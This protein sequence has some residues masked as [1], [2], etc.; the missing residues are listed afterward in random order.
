MPSKT[1]ERKIVL[2]GAKTVFLSTGNTILSKKE[3]DSWSGRQKTTSVNHVRGRDGHYHEGGPFYT[4]A[5]TYSVPHRDVKVFDKN[6]TTVYQGPLFLSPPLPGIT[7]SAHR[8]ED[9]SDLDKFGAEAISRV[10]P[11]NASSHLAQQVGELHQDGIVRSLPGVATWRNRTKVL[12]AAGSEYLSAVFG[13][14]PLVDEI[15][16]VSNNIRHSDTILKNYDSG[17]GRNSHREYEFPE[18]QSSGPSGSQTGK[19]ANTVLGL[20]SSFNDGP[21]GTL[22]TSSVTTVKRWFSGSFTYPPAPK[23][24]ALDKVRYAAH[25]ADYLLGTTL[26]PDVVWEL[27]PWSWAIDWFSNAGEV[28]NNFTNMSVN[29]LVMRYG[30]MMEEKTTTITNTLDDCGLVGHRGPAPSSSV[31][32]KSKV[33]REAN[34]FGFGLSWEGLSPS[35]LLITAALGITHLR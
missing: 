23:H 13:W 9:T 33:R 8:P 24:D 22:T 16:N 12:K 15:T 25:Q 7:N 31:T 14:L 1:R 17:A 27:T 2:P 19:R 11:T 30:Y 4:V 29:G 20:G 35:Q 3:G 28:V 34:P 32:I 10:S 6:K 21:G 5:T 26:T 18:I